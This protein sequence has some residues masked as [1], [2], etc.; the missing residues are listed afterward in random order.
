M[1]SM[2]KQDAELTQKNQNLKET[3]EAESKRTSELEKQRVY[4]Q[5]KQYIEEAAKKIGFVYPDEIV[6]KPKN[7]DQ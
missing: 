5:T 4:V 6:L 1:K 7:E 3:Y 2:K